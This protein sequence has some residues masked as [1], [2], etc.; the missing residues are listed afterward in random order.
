MDQQNCGFFGDDGRP[1]RNKLGAGPLLFFVN[2]QP[3]ITTAQ[4]QAAANRK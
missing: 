2:A 1:K 4:A 3:I